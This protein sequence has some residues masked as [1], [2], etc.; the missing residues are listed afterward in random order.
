MWAVNLKTN[1]LLQYIPKRNEEYFDFAEYDGNK[2][3]LD[4]QLEPLL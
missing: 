4:L 1:F 3:Q 2:G